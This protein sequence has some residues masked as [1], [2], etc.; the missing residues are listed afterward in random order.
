MCCQGCLA[1]AEW[2]E[3]LGLADYYAMR[4]APG[5]KPDAEAAA[6]HAAWQNADN[7]RHVVRDLGGDLR[8][9]LLLIEG[10]RCTAC[11]WLIERSVSG[12][13]DTGASSVRG[14]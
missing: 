11:V 14:F 7:A 4:A 9:S 3:Q 13:R 5:H 2:I 10:I 6:A 1:A 12:A 8:E